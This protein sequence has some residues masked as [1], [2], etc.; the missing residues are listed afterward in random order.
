[1]DFRILGPPAPGKLD[2][3]LAPWRG[4]ALAD[5]VYESWR[6]VEAGREGDLYRIVSPAPEGE[7]WAFDTGSLVRCEQF[8][9]PD[10]PALVAVKAA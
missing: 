10:R 5:F 9:F 8:Q 1:M 7:R 4:P 6:P 3:A 2:D